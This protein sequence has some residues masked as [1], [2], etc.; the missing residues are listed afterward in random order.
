MSQKTYAKDD[1][2]RKGEDL[3]DRDLR[4]ILEPT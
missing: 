1:I 3:Y 4:A 2:V